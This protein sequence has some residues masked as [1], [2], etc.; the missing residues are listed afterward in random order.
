MPTEFLSE[1]KGKD[2]MRGVGEGEDNI[3]FNV[4]E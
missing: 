1:E 3:K 4:R 2:E